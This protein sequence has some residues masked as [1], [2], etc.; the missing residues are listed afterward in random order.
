MLIIRKVLCTLLKHS[1]NIHIEL[2][3][4]NILSTDILETRRP[5]FFI[6]LKL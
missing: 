3:L 1:F 5:K 6:S 2:S 4:I